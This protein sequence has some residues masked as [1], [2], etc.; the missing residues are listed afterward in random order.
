MPESPRSESRS[1]RKRV[2][3]KRLPPLPPGPKLQF[4]IANRPEDFKSNAMMRQVRSHVMYQHRSVSPSG[5]VRSLDR[6]TR[7]RPD[8]R[9]PSPTTTSLSDGIIDETDYSLMPGQNSHGMDDFGILYQPI[10][11]SA[12]EGSRNIASR[13]IASITA[14]PVRSA[15]ATL[16]HASEFP[17]T[18]RDNVVS[19]ESLAELREQYISHTDIIFHHE[20]QW[21]NTVCSYRMSFLSHVSMMCTYQD[22]AE[23]FLGDSAL[24]ECAKSK[25]L[26]MITDSMRTQAGQTED[27]TILS[28]LYLL[29]S[30]IGGHNERAIDVH[31]EGLMRIVHER[32]G[33]SNLGLDGSLATFLTVVVLNST[34]LRGLLEPT[35]FH[36]FTPPRSISEFTVQPR[37]I[38]PLYAPHGD[39]TPLYGT[40]SPRTHGII[41]DMHNVTRIFTARWDYTSDAF[42]S[43]SQQQLA[44]WDNY[45][46]QTLFNLQKLPSSVNDAAPDW[47]YESCRL[48]ALIYCISLEE[49]SQQNLDAGNIYTPLLAALYS[50][51]QRTDLDSCWG[52]LCGVLLWVS[53][54]GGRAAWPSVSLPRKFFALHSVRASLALSSRYGEAVVEAQRNMLRVQA[55]VGVK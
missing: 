31:Q 17:F 39:L 36:S 24:T 40:C 19:Q 25:V 49:A 29:I 21:I 26:S 22:L 1:E 46:Q 33:L 28:I 10:L 43:I 16:D 53:L 42:T 47:I 8:T 38:S 11:Q 41:S 44:I 15:P 12:P 52:E 37:L 45:L 18:T 55:L 27:F 32:G 23:G 4:V 50:A 35:P 9:T 30:E 3:R 6:S 7:R 34:V 13:I 5:S 14:E 20:P 51:L 54:V 48:A 2:G